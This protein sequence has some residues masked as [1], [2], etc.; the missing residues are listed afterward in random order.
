[1]SQ[2]VVIE[3]VT[4]KGATPYLGDDS[5]GSPMFSRHGD[6]VMDWL[7]SAWRSRFN[8]L[9]SRRSCYDRDH[10][11][12]PIGSS[13]DDRT[14]SQA[15]KT[16]S[17]MAA[18]PTLILESPEK[19]ERTDWFA[20]VSR[21]NTLKRNGR[22]PG[23]MPGYRSRKHTDQVFTCWSN[24]GRN[25]RFEPVNRNHGIVTLTG[26]NPT[27]VRAAGET[28]GRFR[29]R[30]HIRI[31]E[32]VRE[33]T[34]V[35]V[36]W[37]T[38]TLVFTNPPAPRVHSGSTSVVGVD[39]GVTHQAVTSTGQVTDLPVD[40]LTRIDREIRRRQKAQ[41]RAVKVAGC[42]DQR[43]Y[44]RRG[45]SHRFADHDGIIGTLK[46]TARNIVV[47]VQHKL[48]TRLVTGNA[49]VVIEDLAVGNMT[50]SPAPV[51]DPV[52]PGRFLPNGAASKRG[53]NRVLSVASMGRLAEMLTYKADATDGVTVV[54]VDPR[55]TSR[56]CPRC[57]H[58]DRTNRKSQA[59]FRCV[60]CGLHGNADY[61]ASINIAARG[62]AQLQGGAHP[63]VEVCEPEVSF[64]ENTPRWTC[65]A[66]TSVTD[67]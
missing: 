48:S 50:R 35:Q 23:R 62:V 22:Y 33:Y 40:R 49:V 2:K 8:Q 45:V 11:L 26:Q 64:T 41:A 25:A 43:E 30:L 12:V 7:T 20:S 24:G 28:S 58:T 19:I 37:T 42:H 32:P 59:V 39:R 21:R 67:R 60:S 65:E 46:E 4:V 52:R 3:R 18:V 53:L 1:M 55:N 5:D 47:D 51:A 54:K 10:N 15:R 31:S 61:V 17:W 44:R 16:C 13:V 38:R 6:D 34:S 9:R 29:I 56:H 57:G 27:G 14:P 63:G 66:R 36:N